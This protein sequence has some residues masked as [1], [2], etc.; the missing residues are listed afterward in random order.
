MSVYYLTI[1]LKYIVLGQI[2]KTLSIKSDLSTI[3][4]STVDLSFET[5]MIAHPNITSSYG[6]LFT[7]I[8]QQRVKHNECKGKYSLSSTLNTNIYIILVTSTQIIKANTIHVYKIHDISPYI[9][10][11]SI[12]D[13]EWLMNSAK[14]FDSPEFE[15]LLKRLG[16]T[17]KFEHTANGTSLTTSYRK[18]I[19]CNAYHSILIKSETELGLYDNIVVLWN[20]YISEYPDK[21]IMERFQRYNSSNSIVYIDLCDVSVE[22]VLSNEKFVRGCLDL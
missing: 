14:Y 6:S 7:E 11:L 5:D 15:S 1:N 22:D 12:A 21:L 17:V 16:P 20:T 19:F 2:L 4:G 10:G 8:Q 3:V 18:L 13:K 9:K